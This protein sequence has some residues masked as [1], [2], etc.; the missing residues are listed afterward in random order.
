MWCFCFIL[1]LK[2]SEGAWIISVIGISAVGGKI[3]FGVLSQAFTKTGKRT[4][5]KL[6][7]ASVILAG[8]AIACAPWTSTYSVL[9]II[10]GTFG[11]MSG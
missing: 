4:N 8:L 1:G 5:T 3:F 10:G 11:F 2:K 6:N 7:S 9:L